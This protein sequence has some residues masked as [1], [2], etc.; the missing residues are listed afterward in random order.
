MKN[1]YKGSESVIFFHIIRF[2]KGCRF[3]YQ[4]LPDIHC[5]YSLFVMSMAVSL[6]LGVSNTVLF[7]SRP[8]F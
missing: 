2:N 8:E 6:F 5:R 1:F 7:K 3:W 4:A